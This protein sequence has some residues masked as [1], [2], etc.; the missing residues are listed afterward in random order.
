MSWK[1]VV[2]DSVG[3]RYHVTREKRDSLIVIYTVASAFRVVGKHGR[4]KVLV[5]KMACW[6]DGRPD[7]P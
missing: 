3:I 7:R 6:M 1:P 4:L 5:F 2:S